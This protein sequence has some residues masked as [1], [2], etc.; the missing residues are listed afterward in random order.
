MTR[1]ALSIRTLSIAAALPILALA[2][3]SSTSDALTADPT[4]AATSTAAPST[5]GTET[6][7]ALGEQRTFGSAS[8]IPAVVNGEPITRNQLSRRVAFMKLRRDRNAG[9][10]A[11][12]NELIDEAV[13]L[14][15]ARRRGVNVPD[16]RVND[17]YANFAKSNRMTVA[18]LNKV[19]NQSG[20]TPAGFKDYIR[21]QIA[22]SSLVAQREQ[23]GASSV[24]TE[25]EAVQRMLDRGGEKPTATE[26]L[27]QQVIFL[28]PQQQR[29]NSAVAARKR[30]AEA[31][32]QRFTSCENTAQFAKGLTDVTVRDLG[33]KLGPELP[34]EWKSLIEKTRAG[35]TTSVRTTP[36]GAEFVAVC[37]TRE[38][39]DD[40]TAQL[41]FAAEDAKDA[42]GDAGK[43]YLAQLKKKAT[44]EVR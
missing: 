8:Q 40:R 30:E 7:A 9:T 18:Q 32:R 17:A 5:A 37:R 39:S 14:Q 16:G 1:R 12:R 11:A 33:R 23:A 43:A 3:C 15:E 29:S 13:K 4:S 19:L 6:A 22:W 25:R 24:I 31:L 10:T 21:V 36:R 27:L 28:V 42:G 41:V 38:V 34:A 35:Q 44:I 20:V 2:G 26:Y